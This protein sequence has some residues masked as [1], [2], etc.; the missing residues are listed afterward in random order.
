MQ[1]KD[2]LLFIAPQAYPCKTGGLEVFNYYLINE[3]KGTYNTHLLTDC[4]QIEAS[5]LKIHKL[6]K[7]S[8]SKITQ[9]IS[10]ISFIFKHRKEIKLIHLSYAKAYWT[11]WAIYP[12]AKYIWNINY[13]FTIHGGGLSKWKPALP[14]KLFFKNATSITGVSDRIIKE[15]TKRSNKEIIYTPPLIPFNVLE[16]YANRKDWKIDDDAFVLLYVGSL[17]PL[18][19]VDTL[20]EAL[21]IITH[22]KLQEKNIKVLIAGDGVSRKELEERVKELNLDTIVSFLGLIDRSEVNKLYSI[23]NMYTICSEFEGLPISLL[24]AFANELPCITSDAPGL[25]DVS[26]DNENTIMFTCKDQLDY[27]EKLELLFADASLRNK[28][29]KS[30]KAYFEEHYS[31]KIVVNSFKEIIDKANKIV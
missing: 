23:A 18:K 13:I 11:H 29:K 26:L 31:Y 16:G 5:N 24:E 10:I 9:P 20:I 7:R 30:A 22:K 15:Y 27:A 1:N 25:I 19:S 21:G 6:K 17:K 28:I 14:Y 2:W 12:I 4:N 3:L 8:L